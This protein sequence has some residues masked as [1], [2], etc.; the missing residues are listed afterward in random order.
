MQPQKNI[1][2]NSLCTDVLG[3]PFGKVPFPRPFD[4]NPEEA[5]II[6]SDPVNPIGK[7]M[8]TGKKLDNK[9]LKGMPCTIYT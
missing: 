8:L 6:L 9:V 2:S 4:G 7:E 5:K 3:H 1:I